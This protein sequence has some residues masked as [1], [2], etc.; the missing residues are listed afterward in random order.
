MSE[1]PGGGGVA[2]LALHDIGPVHPGGGD[3]DEDFAVFGRGDRAL[4]GFQHLRSA[5]HL[6]LDRDH[7]RGGCFVGHGARVGA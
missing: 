7:G 3:L 6:D 1:A 5:R 2:S 4:L